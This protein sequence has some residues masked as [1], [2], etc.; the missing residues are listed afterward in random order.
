MG[1]TYLLPAEYRVN[2]TPS[3]VSYDEPRTHTSYTSGGSGEE[4]DRHSI[5]AIDCPPD[6]INSYRQSQIR[7]AFRTR[8]TP[9]GSS[10]NSNNINNSDNN[11]KN[12]ESQLHQNWHP[13]RCILNKHRISG[14]DPVEE[15]AFDDDE[16]TLRTTQ[17]YAQWRE[18][19]L[20]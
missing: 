20:R 12:P 18:R 17:S 19:M 15:D 16:N 1:A 10:G 8:S 4:G 6:A 9:T 13:H 2:R 7:E 5:R 14:G 3:G 11:N